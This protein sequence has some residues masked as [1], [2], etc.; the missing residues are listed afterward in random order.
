[1]CPS[2]MSDYD[3]AMFEVESPFAQGVIG[4]FAKGR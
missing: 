1:M 3:T 2:L 4:I